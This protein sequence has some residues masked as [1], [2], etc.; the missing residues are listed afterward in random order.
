M[1][2]VV[3]PRHD[4]ILPAQVRLVR[5]SVVRESV[6]NQLSKEEPIHETNSIT[7]LGVNIVH[8]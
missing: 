3:L 8:R 7:L 1:I 4:P 2:T 5:E 6:V